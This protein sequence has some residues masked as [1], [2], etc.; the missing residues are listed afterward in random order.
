MFERI[1][2]VAHNN[3]ANCVRSPKAVSP[4]PRGATSDTTTCTHTTAHTIPVH[5]PGRFTEIRLTLRVYVQAEWLGHY[6]SNRAK[7]V[8]LVLRLSNRSRLRIGDQNRIHR[9]RSCRGAPVQL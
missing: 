5:L 4:L 9:D 1:A 8:E 6:G 7:S 2:K 3:R